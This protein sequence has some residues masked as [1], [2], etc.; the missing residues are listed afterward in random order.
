MGGIVLVKRKEVNWL[1]ASCRGLDTN[2][3]YTP[4]AELLEQGISYRNL[5]RICF[6]CPIWKECLQVAVQEEPYGFWGGLSEEER[7]HLY[8]GTRPRS[9]KQLMMD[10]KICNVNIENIKKVV[11]SVKRNFSYSAPSQI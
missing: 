10:L 11:K 5:R 4:M 7:R 8:N 6:N 9:M 2:L 3:F 1:D